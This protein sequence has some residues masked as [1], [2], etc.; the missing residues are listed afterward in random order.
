MVFLHKYCMVLVFRLLLVVQAPMV[1]HPILGLGSDCEHLQ[2][3]KLWNS[4]CRQKD[5]F[6]YQLFV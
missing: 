3:Q 4:L 1:R 5:V 6:L 2:N